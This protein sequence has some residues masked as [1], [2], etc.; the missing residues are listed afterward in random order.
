MEKK[1]FK[2]VPFV[3]LVLR[4]DNKILLQR[5]CN[6]KYCNHLYACPGGSVD[7]DESL[8]QATIREAKEELGI[9]LKKEDLRI[10]HV[11]HFKS[12]YGEFINFF[13]E[14]REWD[15]EPRIMEPHKC[16]DLSWFPLDQLPKDVA[17]ENEIVIKSM[18]KGILY[19]ESGF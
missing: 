14:A 19:S 18:I 2:L 16:V 17:P 7:G 8:I 6:T 13:L 15:G 11:I 3:S 4:K 12:Q 1:R 10:V 5:R 9:N